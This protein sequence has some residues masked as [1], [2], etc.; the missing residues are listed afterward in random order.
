MQLCTPGLP[1]VLRAIAHQEDVQPSQLELQVREALLVE[2]AADAGPAIQDLRRDGFRIV[3]DEFGT[4]YSSLSCLRRF[5]VDGIKLNRSFIDLAARDQSVAIIRAAVTL[6]HAM[7]L[8]VVADGISC[9]EEEQ[10]AL[11]SGCD[12][13]QGPLYASAMPL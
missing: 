12:G 1:A 2:H 3:L 5:P 8:E 11:E 7:D 6:G 10:I 4:G 13:V 9:R